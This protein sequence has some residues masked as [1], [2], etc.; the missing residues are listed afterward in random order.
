MKILGKVGDCK[1]GG[2]INQWHTFDL[3]EPV[4]TRM[5]QNTHFLGCTKV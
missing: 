1:V 2:Y 3:I 5:K 4:G